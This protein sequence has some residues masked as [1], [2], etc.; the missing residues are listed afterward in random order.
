LTEDKTFEIIKETHFWKERNIMNEQIMMLLNE[1][2][3]EKKEIGESIFNEKTND[4]EIINFKN[5]IKDYCEDDYSEYLSF[6]EIVNGLNFWGLIIYSLN[7]E[8]EFN[9]CKSN[10][11]WWD[12]DEAKEYIFFGEDG[13]V[14]FCKNIFDRKYYIIDLIHGEIIIIDEFE[15]FDEL[16]IEALESLEEEEDEEE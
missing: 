4:T 15:T 1:I 16:I 5:W 11:E 2:E 13:F 10:K 8:S 9:I 3:D 14:W 6:V 12:L 7:E